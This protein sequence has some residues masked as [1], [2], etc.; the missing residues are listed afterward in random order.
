MEVV[1]TDIDLEQK[2]TVD[3]IEQIKTF[4]F[5][6]KEFTDIEHW[7]WNEEGENG[8]AFYDFGCIGDFH[9]D[10]YK[11]KVELYY[12]DEP[13]Y[14]VAEWGSEEMVFLPVG[15][16]HPKD[17]ISFGYLDFI[18]SFPYPETMNDFIKIIKEFY[19]RLDH[20]KQYLIKTCLK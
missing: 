18:Q 4:N 5:S 12:G 20:H 13:G 1:K 2:F 17:F 6:K 15:S 14:G 11:D 16:G 19:K 8:R 3:L 10:I 7:G 9:F